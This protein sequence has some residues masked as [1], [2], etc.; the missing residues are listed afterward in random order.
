MVDWSKMKLPTG[1]VLAM[2]LLGFVLMFGADFFVPTSH[3]SVGVNQ[4]DLEKASRDNPPVDFETRYELSLK[5]TISRVAGAGEVSVDVF[6]A[7][8]SRYEYAHNLDSTQKTTQDAGANSLSK[9]TTETR[10]N[11][12]VTIKRSTGGEEPVVIQTTA[13]E[14]QGV[15]IIATGAS[16]PVIKRELA[17]A[18]Q[19]AL[20]IPIHKVKVLPKEVR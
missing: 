7:S 18:V 13:P 2:A 3:N 19:T 14:I 8:S 20:G 6:L 15:L 10:S 4:D 12:Q 11:S 5:D 1:A 9:I 17:K 16:D